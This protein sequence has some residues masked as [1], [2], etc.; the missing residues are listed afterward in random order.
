MTWVV[1]VATLVLAVL[2]GMWL[3]HRYRLAEPLTGPARGGIAD[4]GPATQDMAGHD[5]QG[6]DPASHDIT[7]HETA[8]QDLTTRDTATHDTA[9][10]DMSNHDMAGH[11]M[12]GDRPPDRDVTSHDA[13][14]AS[15]GTPAG[16]RTIL[17]WWDPMMPD[18]RSDRP[19]KS[20]MGMDMVPVYAEETPAAEAGAVRIAPEIVDSLGVRT[21]RAETGTLQHRVV[22]GGFVAYDES[23]MT[24]VHATASGRVGRL[25]VTSPGERVQGGDPVL[26]IEG[27]DGRSVSVIAPVG[28]L[29]AELAEV[30]R[31]MEIGAGTEIMTLVDAG[32][33]WV[34]GEVFESD[35]GWLYVGQPVEARFPERP[36]EV[37]KGAVEVILPK[38][39]YANRTIRY[40][41]RFD[42][43]DGFLLPN[44]FA[45]LT[46][47]GKTGKE[48]VHIPRQAL[49][50]EGEAERVIIALGNGRFAPRTVTAGAEFGERLEI[51]SG[52]EAGEEIVTSA[53]FLIDSE[54]SLQ[55]SLSRL[56]G[57]APSAHHHH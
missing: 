51:R 24:R 12:A 40:R 37:W 56:D 19:G 16:E 7:S 9:S 17:Y 55:A 22:S 3:Q 31:G 53:Q 39:E 54:A 38:V 50:R 49:I 29:V 10:H 46:L 11:D 18:Y 36:G 6:H 42:N 4:R 45:E 2:L 8:G 30:Y 20:P 52:L 28:G 41:A 15:A 43:P 21:A 1:R 47:Y 34:K 48:V 44:M 32:T 57:G 23:R 27:D 14:A 26:E 13:P 35:G 5:M 33:V 25:L